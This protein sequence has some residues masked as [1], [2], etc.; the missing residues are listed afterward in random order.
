MPVTIAFINFAVSGLT[1]IHQLPVPLLPVSF[2][3]NLIT[4]IL[5]TINSLS[6]NYPCLQQIKN[7]LART[8]VKAPTSC[9][10]T[11]ILPSL[12][13]LRITERIKYKLLW[14]TY[15]VL[16]TRPPYLHNL[17]SVLRPRSTR[18]SSMVT[19]SRP[20]WSSSLKITPR[21]F[22]Y[23][24]PCLWNQLFLSLCLPHC[25]TS[26]FIFDSLIPLPSH[27]LFWLTTLLIHNSLSP[28]VAYLFHKSYFRC[29]SS[30]S[31]TAFMDYCSDR[32]FSATQF[33][34]LVFP[35]FCFFAVL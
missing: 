2:T 23:A 35:I 21:S 1:S 31:W 12:H 9:H 14:L 22:C 18:F 19:L 27:I 4:V 29:F 8:I 17:I 16:T 11:P 25:D 26:S 13:W 30:S 7:S 6:C 32:F 15:K 28:L 33:L 34:F 5:C 20:P 3:P 10:I 24:L